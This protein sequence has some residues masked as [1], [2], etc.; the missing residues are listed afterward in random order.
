MR[1]VTAAKVC[2]DL[3]KSARFTVP[4]LSTAGLIA[5]CS[6]WAR[7]A[8]ARAGQRNDPGLETAGNLVN[9]WFSFPSRQ[10][11]LRPNWTR[12]YSAIR[13]ARR[14]MR[15]P[16]ANLFRLKKNGE[17]MM[18]TKTKSPL[19]YDIGLHDGR[20]TGHYLREGCR[21][22]AIDANPD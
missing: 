16:S 6:H 21:V 2:L 22:V 12:W 14:E 19:V 15:D 20:D 18:T 8:V 9:V 13:P 17:P 10:S 3:A 4:V 7:F 11:I 1:Q 5:L